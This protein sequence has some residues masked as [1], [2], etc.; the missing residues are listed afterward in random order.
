[1]ESNNELKQLNIKNC[2]CFYFDN[3]ININDL[4]IDEIYWMKK[5]MKMF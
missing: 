5:Q 2:L 4:D 3:I 1:M